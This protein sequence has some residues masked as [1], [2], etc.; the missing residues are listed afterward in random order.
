MIWSAPSSF[1]DTDKKN[2]TPIIADRGGWAQFQSGAN[3]TA[4]AQRALSREKNSPFSDA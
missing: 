1:T 2:G 3:L 4:E